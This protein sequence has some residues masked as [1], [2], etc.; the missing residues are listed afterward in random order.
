M[1]GNVWEWCSDRYDSRYYTTL[2]PKGVKNPGGPLRSYDPDEPLA[3]KR[4]VRG[5]SFLCN[6]SYCTGYRV[7]RRMKTTEDSGMEHLGFRCVSD[8]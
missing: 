8:H 7:S 6:E 3:Q 4:V 2:D 5:G 1:A